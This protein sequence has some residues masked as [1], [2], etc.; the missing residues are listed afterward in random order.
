MEY[1]TCFAGFFATF[2]NHQ[3]IVVHVQ[4]LDVCR[5]FGLREAVAARNT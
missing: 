4:V 1:T 3:E 2:E 5:L